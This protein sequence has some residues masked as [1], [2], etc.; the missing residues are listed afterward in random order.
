MVG[1]RR[2]Q[3]KDERFHLGPEHRTQLVGLPGPC[4]SVA[5]GPGGQALAIVSGRPARVAVGEV[6]EHRDPRGKLGFLL[7][8][9]APGL[10]LDAADD[11]R[12]IEALPVG[13]VDGDGELVV[14]PAA[15]RASAPLGQEELPG[16]GQVDLLQRAGRLLVEEV[17]Q[18]VA[19]ELEFVA[20]GAGVLLEVAILEI[21]LE[22]LVDPADQGLPG[23]F[24][25]VGVGG[26]VLVE[27]LADRVVEVALG[28][29]AGG[30]LGVLERGALDVARR[31]L[32]AQALADPLGE[33]GGAVVGVEEPV[34]RLL[35]L[36]VDHLQDHVLGRCPLEQ[37]LAERVHPLPLLIHDLVVFEKVLAGIEVP[38]LDLFLGTLDALG[39]HPALDGLALLASP[40]GV[41]DGRDPLA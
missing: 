38:L 36:A 37:A 33:R 34:G 4:G 39:D 2:G 41:E 22:P 9:Q 8:I 28:L 32:D 35:D 23:P 21:E 13:G 10:G 15:Q 40:A 25:G 14:H 31:Q 16:G 1:G 12:A 27:G 30:C 19:A 3:V 7:D 5:R 24:R 17:L 29:V 18:V 20:V 11:L 6:A 26:E